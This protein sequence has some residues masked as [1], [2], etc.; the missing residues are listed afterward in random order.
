MKK[1][2][3]LLCTLGIAQP[4][5]AASITSLQTLGQAEFKTLSEDLG[6]AL[7]YK[8]VTPAAPLGVIGFDV[9]I[10][11]TQTDM[12]KSTAAWSKAT[13]SSSSISKLYIPKFHVAK[14]L[15]FGID[16]AAFVSKIPTTNISL[17]GAELRYAILDGGLAMPAVAV[18]GAFTKLG[19]VDQLSFSTKS[20]DLSIS[21]GFLMFTPY[22]GVGQVWVNS[23]ANVSSGALSL[24]STQTFTQSKVFGGIN[25]NLLATNLA[26]EVD[27]T[28][29]VKSAS[30][31]VGFRF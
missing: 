5:M 1:L 9:G 29:G 14:G 31:K 22:A 13:G 11:A 25:V 2:L 18:R 7:S 26:L 21:K 3:V 27:K 24:A 4:A 12:S 23:Q 19:G 28:G 20:V 30:V 16:V 15:P 10:E 8:P 6:A 17:A